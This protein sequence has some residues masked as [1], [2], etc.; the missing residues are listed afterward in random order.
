M[1]SRMVN[2][3]LGLIEGLR[4]KLLF[5]FNMMGILFITVLLGTAFVDLPI[6]HSK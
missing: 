1:Y 3:Y 5:F 2:K 4:M 6:L